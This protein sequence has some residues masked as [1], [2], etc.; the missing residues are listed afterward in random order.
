MTS[1]GVALV[2]GASRGIGRAI[3]LRLASD[4]F[5]VAINDLPAAQEGL[6]TLKHEIVG[7]GR[8]ACIAVG[9]VSAQAHVKDMVSTAIEE[10]GQL[11]VMVA[12]A[13][14]YRVTPITETSVD[15]WDQL[16]AVN[17]RGLFLCYKYA[18]LQ[19]IKQGHGGR[20][21]G[22]SSIAGRE[23]QENMATY[24]ATKF[25]VR[26]LTQAAAKEWGRHGI[27][28]NAYCPGVIE[29]D[30]FE[31][32]NKGPGT[33]GAAL[34]KFAEGCALGHNATPA[35]V[36]SLVSYLA[37]KEAHFIT[38]QSIGIDEDDLD[39]IEGCRGSA[40]SGRVYG[41]I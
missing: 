18:G 27:T 23:G 30:I 19:M 3:A 9:D 10:L 37:S 15:E 25:A 13:G 20:I 35:E 39:G 24:S 40:V 38:G 31:A 4:G 41:T 36:A 1:L 12:N 17:A 21:I 29:T 32:L 28:V 7:K 5:N 6:N 14:I 33:V 34:K 16:F 8:K 11:D 2:T 22:A 26:G